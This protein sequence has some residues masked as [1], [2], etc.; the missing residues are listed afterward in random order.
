MWTV[1]SV[2]FLI[3]G[4]YSH[5]PTD[6][7]VNFTANIVKSS[8]VLQNYVRNRNGFGFDDTPT[9]NDFEEVDLFNNSET[10]QNANR[11]CNAPRL[12]IL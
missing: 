1:L 12:I 7:E 10:N 3:N 2:Y 5:R 8:C 9:I 11:F 6:I 4:A